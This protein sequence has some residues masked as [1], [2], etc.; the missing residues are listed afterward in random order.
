MKSLHGINAAAF[1]LLL[2]F[3]ASAPLRYGG[4]MPAGSMMIEGL[5][6][7]VAAAAFF[8]DSRPLPLGPASVPVGAVTAIALLGVIQLLPLPQS[9]LETLS[10]TSAKIYHETKEIVI[11]FGGKGVPEGRISIAPTETAAAV[12]LVLAYVALFVS[13]ALLLH[14]RARRRLVILTLFATS[15]VQIIAA[16]L[17]ETSGSRIHGAFVNPNHFAGYLEIMLA[18]AFG[19]LWAEI[20]TS[21]ERARHTADR[22]ERFEKRF[23]PLAGRILIWGLI[24]AGIGL[25]RSRGGMASATI[26]T[27]VLLSMA[28]LHHRVRWRRRHLALGA[29]LAL[30]AGLFFVAASTRGRP[31]L[32]FLASDPRDIGTDMRLALWRT[33][34]HAWQEFPVFGSGLGTFR[35]AFRRVQP[36]ELR[37][38]V[39]QAHSDPLQLLVTGGWIGASLGM[40]AFA[41]LFFLLARAWHRQTHREES[42]FVL[43]GFGALLSL[44]IHGI[45]EFNF[46]VPAIPATL[47]CVLGAAWAA[48]RSDSRLVAR[49]D[50]SEV[51][52]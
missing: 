11:L 14:D 23:L 49:Y 47:A 48:G 27:L 45:A 9:S 35:E 44:T 31:L 37:G 2:I 1:T 12:L 39:E 52:P 6:F 15:G 30:L 19:A 21:R 40:L 50:V 46:S 5:A 4:I 3:A 33:S 22:A 42:A 38:L 28:L 20:L 16:A 29:T 17:T 24:A 26:T 25:T 32:R 43:A 8:S 7:V 41:S 34:L 51:P 18:L 36:R 13:A 10:A